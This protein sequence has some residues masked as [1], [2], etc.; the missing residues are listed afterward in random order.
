[1]LAST[2]P[3]TIVS[4]SLGPRC[5]HQ[6]W[7]SPAAQK[8]SAELYFAC[9]EHDAYAPLEM[10]QALDASLKAE[11]EV[12]PG[13]VGEAMK[14]F[15]ANPQD[16][17]AIATLS[18]EVAVNP[19]LRT[20]CV[21]TQIQGGH[22]PNALPQKAWANINCRIFPGTSVEAVRAKLEELV[23]D[24]AVS[25]TTLEMRGPTASPPPLSRDIMEPIEALTAEFWPGV[26]VLPILQAGGT[27]GVFTNAAGIPTYGLE[28]VFIGPD[29]GHI[30]GLNEYVGVQSLFEGREF[31]YRLV[32]TYAERK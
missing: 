31:L 10:V 9:A 12:T 6:S 11:G 30:H 28:P 26:P 18:A 32:K 15:A 25:V 17:A 2:F 13:P 27:D 4:R 24:P 21:A 19:I 7:K 16:A 5:L 23:A 8:A 3:L 14:A 29:L 22:A 1:V 20:T